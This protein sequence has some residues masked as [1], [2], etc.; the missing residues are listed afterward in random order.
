[1]KH[2]AL[3][4]VLIVLSAAAQA[5]TPSTKTQST[6]TAAGVAA[7][8]QAQ[9]Y[10][11]IQNLHRGPDGKWVGNAT[12]NGVPSTVTVGPQGDVTAR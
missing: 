11:E 5:Q 4:L 2:G 10:S 7:R 1:M 8:L 12:R 9:G 6:A 3:L